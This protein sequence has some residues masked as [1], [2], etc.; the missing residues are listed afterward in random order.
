MRSQG[1][2]SRT[3]LWTVL[4]LGALAVIA[5]GV[6]TSRAED[7]LKIGFA[8]PKTGY[9]GVA[10]PVAIQA[11]ELWRDQVNAAGGLSIGG[12]EK[13]KVEFVSYDDQS[14]PTKTAQIYERLITVDKV[15]LLLAPYATPFHIAIA[16]VVERHKFPIIGAAAASTL[17]RDLKVKYMF[18]AEVLPDRYGKSI[19]AFLKSQGV[20]SVGMITLQLPLSLETKKYAQPNLKD[21]GIKAVVDNEYPV[22]IKDMTGMLS[23]LKSANPNAVLGLTYPEDSVLYVNTARELGFVNPIQFLLIGPSEPFFIKKFPAKDTEGF[24]T[25]GHWAPT[26]AGWP[27]A[28]PF[29]DAYVAK[30]NEPPDFL[31]SVISYISCEILQQAVEKVGLDHDKI[32]DEIANDTFD[33]ING[34]VK[35]T[36]GENLSLP[37][38]LIQI[39]K[40]TLEVIWPPE[41]ATAKFEPKGGWSK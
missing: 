1:K 40:G 9:L 37:A 10:S 12:K 31:D 16:P 28:K 26:E 4:V 30:W 11:Y 25:M 15:D 20:Q 13:R 34:P 19:P 36:N 2:L 24:I 14:V 39:Q 22:D 8:M 6:G 3:S 18:M 7:T 32:R 17:M 38:G 27:K 21:A 41:I 35:F 5:I 23:A 33:T 29:Y